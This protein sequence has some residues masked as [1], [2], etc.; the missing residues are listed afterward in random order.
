MTPQGMLLEFFVSE[1]RSWT[2]LITTP[3]HCSDRRVL[4]EFRKPEAARGIGMP[5]G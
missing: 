2:I 3:L 5:D 1:A 4:R